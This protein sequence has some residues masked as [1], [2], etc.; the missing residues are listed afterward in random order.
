MPINP[1]I[2][3]PYGFDYCYYRHY[4]QMP[5]AELKKLP[6]VHNI[7]ITRC[8]DIT[9]GLDELAAVYEACGQELNGMAVRSRAKWQ[10]LLNGYKAEKVMLA[11]AF[12]DASTAGYMLYSLDAGT[13]KVQELLTLSQEAQTA[14]LRYA[15]G[16]LSDAANFEWLAEPGN[17]AYLDFAGSTYSGSLKPF[18]MARCINIR[19]AL[20]LLPVPQNVSGE[21]VLLI[22]DKFLPLNNGLLKIT[23]QNGALTQASTIE[24]EEI[25]MDSAAFTQLYFG[26]FSFE[27]LVRAGKIKVHNPRKSGFLQALFTKCRNYINEYY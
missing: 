13:F 24:N 22:T 10:E 15:A 14:L 12:E 7:K 21:A 2:Y 11:I 26:A 19:K 16:H 4:Y 20:E 18:M 17:M 3:K 9:E 5:L 1:A 27:E 8:A 25:T 23:A 6:P